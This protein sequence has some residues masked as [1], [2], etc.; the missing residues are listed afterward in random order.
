LKHLEYN[1]R[2]FQFTRRAKVMQF[3]INSHYQTV[4]YPEG[5]RHYIFLQRFLNNVPFLSPAGGEVVLESFLLVWFSCSFVTVSKERGLIEGQQESLSA[6]SL[7]D[8]ST[9]K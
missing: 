9:R 2:R 6:D 3:H 5:Q 8:C 4:L 1:Q 7:S